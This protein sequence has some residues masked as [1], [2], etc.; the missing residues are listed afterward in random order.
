MKAFKLI[1]FFVVT[2]TF[3]T[4][5]CWGENFTTLW[6]IGESDENFSEFAIAGNF[7]K[8]SEKFGDTVDFDLDSD[9]AE[10]AWPY[11]QPGPEDSWAKSRRD[12]F[13]IHFDCAAENKYYKLELG[14]V[15]AQQRRPPKL[16]V[17]L[18]NIERFIQTIG[19][20]GDCD[21]RNASTGKKQ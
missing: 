19:G 2:V 12:S 6:S 20:S 7:S 9:K 16:K 4:G 18:N 17:T 8:F 1:L 10:T 5:I 14:F 21:F 3:F 11:V 15:S 13:K